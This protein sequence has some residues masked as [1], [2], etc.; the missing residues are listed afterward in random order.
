M[1]MFTLQPGTLQI[2]TLVARGHCPFPGS[3]AVTLMGRWGF[4]DFGRGE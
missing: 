2:C 4:G 1:P 3:H